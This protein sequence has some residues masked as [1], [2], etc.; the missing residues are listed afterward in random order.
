MA[1]VHID[2]NGMGKRVLAIAKRFEASSQ[3]RAYIEAMRRFSDSVEQASTTALQAIVQRMVETFVEPVDPAEPVDLAEPVETEEHERKSAGG[4]IVL[5]RADGRLRLPFR[6]IVYGGDD[7]T[8]VCD[9]RLALDLT[10]NYLTLLESTEIDDSQESGDRHLYVRAGVAVVKNHYPFA[11]G[12]ALAEALAREAK[13]MI[14]TVDGPAS[15]LDWHFAVNGLVRD[16]ASIR[17]LDYRS[18]E[19]SQKRPLHMRPLL[20]GDASSDQPR[21]WATFAA[22]RDHFADPNG[23]WHDKNNKRKALR[24]KLRQGESVV[25]PFME[26]LGK[27]HW[28]PA[29]PGHINSPKSGWLPE[30]CIWF[31]ALEALDFNISL[32]ETVA[33]AEEEGA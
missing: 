5:N 30:C 9:G 4:K 24:E 6:P 23:P 19:G 28:L 18:N 12:Y 32:D 8:F 33:T 17:R 3:N 22:M 7:I 11:R 27:R 16:I 21:T 14:Q 25:T 20:L 2:G 31:D 13:K 29:I 10:Q 26:R 1:I 15:A